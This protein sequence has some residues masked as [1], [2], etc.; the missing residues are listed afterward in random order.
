MSEINEICEVL[1]VFHDGGIEECYGDSDRLNIKVSCAYLAELVNKGSDH[2]LI[3]LC[4][5]SKFYFEEWLLPIEKGS[6][7]IADLSEI[8]NADTELNTPVIEDDHIKY[9][10]TKGVLYIKCKAIEIRDQYQN[11]IH[12]E[13]L[14]DIANRYWTAK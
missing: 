8:A 12:P 9:F 6:R 14:Y 13:Q 4:G 5:V 7:I 1:S 3:I 11:A 2:F 10:C